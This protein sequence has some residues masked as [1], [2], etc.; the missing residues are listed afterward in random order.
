MRP[1]Q[2]REHAATDMRVPRRQRSTGRR[3]QTSSRHHVTRGVRA[4]AKRSGRLGQGGAAKSADLARQM[5]RLDVPWAR[6]AP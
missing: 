1:E 2:P 5:R 6:S 3:L 4:A